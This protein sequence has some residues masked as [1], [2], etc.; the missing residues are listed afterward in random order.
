M[1]SH[2]Q[3]NKC[4]HFE[5]SQSIKKLPRQIYCELPEVPFKDFN[6]K[7][8]LIEF[9]THLFKRFELYARKDW[10]TF[11]RL[12]NSFSFRICDLLFKFATCCIALMFT[13]FPFPQAAGEANELEETSDKK[14]IF[15]CSVFAQL[16]EQTMNLV[17]RPFFIPVSQLAPFWWF[18]YEYLV[19]R[20]T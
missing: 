15:L 17:H 20:L 13:V 11:L 6:S 3:I 9:Y 2:L 4:H 7:K 1:T 8:N 14:G 12:S 5:S 10:N 19:I 18:S 16:S